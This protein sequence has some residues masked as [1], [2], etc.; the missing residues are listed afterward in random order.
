VRR[1]QQASSML[2]AIAGLLTIF[3]VCLF[4][5]SSVKQR[6]KFVGNPAPDDKLLTNLESAAGNGHS[7]S[8]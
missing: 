6:Q 4:D 5:I 3:S 1:L 8:W 7:V 2:S